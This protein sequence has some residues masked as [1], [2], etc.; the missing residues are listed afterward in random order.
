VPVREFSYVFLYLAAVLSLRNFKL[1][2]ESIHHKLFPVTARSMKSRP[3]ISI[4]IPNYNH[5]DEIQHSLRAIVNQT[6]PADEV[7]VVDDGSSDDSIEI[8]QKIAKD[9]DAIC[10]FMHENNKGVVAAVNAGVARA[11]GDYI[12]LA[13]ADERIMPDMCEVMEN[14]HNLYPDA[15][16]YASKFA[17]WYP[18]TAILN[19]GSRGE[20]DFWFMK[21][22]NP[23]WISAERFSA[24]AKIGH[25]RI[26]ANSA[27]FKKSAMIESGIFDS[28]MRWYSDF[29]LMYTLAFRYGFCA[30]PRTLSWFKISK[31]SFSS[32]GTNQKMEQ[33]AVMQRF[34]NKL[35]SSEYKDLM[36][37][38]FV[39]PATFS[40]FFRP[41][42]LYLLGQP[43]HLGVLVKLAVWWVMDVTR[44][45]RPGVWART[46]LA[47]KLRRKYFA[48]S[49][50]K[51]NQ[52]T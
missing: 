3:R 50:D 27:M 45:N 9:H 11:S 21:N 7:I 46:K 2:T 35:E 48:S 42:I 1:V 38:F 31:S 22:D 34:M 4:V 24:L 51:L 36:D 39:A 19:H 49:L 43:R 52:R 37:K 29:F 18:E 13:S 25:V 8:I 33:H 28:E 23:E 5:S 26:S 12:I 47:T 15:V 30:V 32:T 6:R 20:Y 40:A 14:A 16:V 44:G 17:E 41:L 10:L